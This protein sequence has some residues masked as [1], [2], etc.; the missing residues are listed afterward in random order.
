MVLIDPEYLH[1]LSAR[2]IRSGTAEIIKYGMTHDIHL[3]NEI[4]DNSELNII[5]LIHRSIEIKN[6]V[7]L[8]DPREQNLRKVL[9]FGHT[10]G[11]AIESFYLESKDLKNLTHGE[12]I[13]IGMIMETHLSFQKKYI[14]IEHKFT[15]TTHSRSLHSH[16]CF[17]SLTFFCLCTF[18]ISYSVYMDSLRLVARS[19]AL[20]GALVAPRWGLEYKGSAKQKKKRVQFELKSLCY[21]ITKFI[22]SLMLS[23]R[24]INHCTAKE[25]FSFNFIILFLDLS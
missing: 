3:F 19:M 15:Q 4:K 5:D 8:K 21:F 1:T 6:E 25:V 7:V 23:Y 16:I 22:S 10:I 18:F 17:H 24:N 13:A 11:H 2:E 9:N 14:N 20:S 12:A